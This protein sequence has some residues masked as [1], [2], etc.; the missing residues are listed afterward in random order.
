VSAEVGGKAISSRVVISGRMEL[1]RTTIW[2][3][4]DVSVMR[5]L[6]LKSI[7]GWIGTGTAQKLPG[8]LPLRILLFEKRFALDRL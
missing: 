8:L 3:V 6:G 7:G 5:V 4:G 2:C 1:F